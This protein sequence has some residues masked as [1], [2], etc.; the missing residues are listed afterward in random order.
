MQPYD[1]TIKAQS[2]TDAMMKGIGQGFQLTQMID[3][4]KA[5]DLKAQ[6]LEAQKQ[7]A[8]VMQAD[9]AGL[10]SNKNPNA[11]DYASMMVKYPSLSEHFKKSWD[12]L[13]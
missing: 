6:A 1:Y 10:A 9:L 3:Q 12:I 2:P 13:D 11:Q 5:S 7:Q 8:Q 4:R